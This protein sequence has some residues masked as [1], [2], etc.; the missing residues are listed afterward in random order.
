MQILPELLC[1]LLLCPR[2]FSPSPCSL[3]NRLTGV[4]CE[5]SRIV[6]HCGLHS[7]F[8]LLISSVI[9]PSFLGVCSSVCSF[10]DSF[11]LAVVLHRFPY[12][13]LPDFL[14]WYKKIVHFSIDFLMKK[15]TISMSF[16]C[17]LKLLTAAVFRCKQ[18]YRRPHTVRGR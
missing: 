7:A 8:S 12:R 13:Q 2:L 3:W 5:N 6:N 18:G 15:Y 10:P 4:I 9:P 11:F 16:L 1:Q 17:C 14:L